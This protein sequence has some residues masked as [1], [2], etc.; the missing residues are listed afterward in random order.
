MPK[1]KKEREPHRQLDKRLF[2]FGEEATT[3]ENSPAPHPRKYWQ[4]NNHENEFGIPFLQTRPLHFAIY[5]LIVYVTSCINYMIFNVIFWG[6][7]YWE[8]F[9]PLDDESLPDIGASS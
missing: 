1:E 6:K 9:H 2:H 3:A 7:K 8:K 4:N 5:E